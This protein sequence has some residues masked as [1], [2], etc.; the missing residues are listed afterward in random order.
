MYLS[1]SLPPEW[2]GGQT[3]GSRLVKSWRLVSPNIGQG[4][5][6]SGPVLPVKLPAVFVWFPGDV[7]FL[8][9]PVGFVVNGI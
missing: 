1:V 3:Q 5:N 8:G 4:V 6:P 9:W 2:Q 7:A